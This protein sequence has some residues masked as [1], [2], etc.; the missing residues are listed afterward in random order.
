MLYYCYT[1]KGLYIPISIICTIKFQVVKLYNPLKAK[2]AVIACQIAK[3]CYEL[4]LTVNYMQM[5]AKEF[6][7]VIYIKTQSNMSCGPRNQRALP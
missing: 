6:N 4:L 7:Y 2:L 5:F 1:P 3:F